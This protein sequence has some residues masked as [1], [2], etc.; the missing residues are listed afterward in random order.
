MEGVIE[1]SPVVE[2]TEVGLVVWTPLSLGEGDSELQDDVPEAEGDSVFIAE[3]VCVTVGGGSVMVTDEEKDADT[4]ADTEM[5][6]D[7]VFELSALLVTEAEMVEE[8]EGF[9]ERDAEGDAEPDSGAEPLR[10]ADTD[11]DAERVATELTE[12]EAEAEEEPDSVPGMSVNVGGGGGN[13][14]VA[15]TLRDTEDDAVTDGDNVSTEET[16]LESVA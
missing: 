5:L 12:E 8:P 3:I 14:S 10:L 2:A 11:A 1:L 9:S 16:L 4:V 13:V 7:S 6:P 15:S